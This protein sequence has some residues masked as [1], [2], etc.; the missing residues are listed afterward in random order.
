[1]KTMTCKE[2]GGA[3]DKEF[4]ANTFEELVMMSKMHGMEMFQQQDV[5]HMAVIAE[6]T[7]LMSDP[8][9]MEAWM[10]EKKALFDSK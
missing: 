10:K 6:V 7:K 5:A 4:T 9:A 1:M 2:L 3:C 8:D